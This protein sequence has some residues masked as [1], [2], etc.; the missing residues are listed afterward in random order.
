ME[1]DNLRSFLGAVISI[2]AI[3]NPIGSLPI[4]VS[5]TGNAP[6][7]QRRRV[8]RVAGLVSLAI[9]MSM[10]VAGQFLLNVVFGIRIEEFMLGGGLLLM[11]VGIHRILDS[12]SGS[13]APR[14]ESPEATLSLAVSPIACPLLVGPGSIVTVML[15]VDRAG[16]VYAVGATLAAFFFVILVLMYSHVLYRLIGRLGALALGRIMEIFIVAI[17]VHFVISAVTKLLP[18]LASAP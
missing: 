14:E 3:V 18:G 2:F 11:V 1:W 16:L 6:P 8:M 5:L 4:L 13:T 7:A 10:A 15:L 9:I 12:R 17:G